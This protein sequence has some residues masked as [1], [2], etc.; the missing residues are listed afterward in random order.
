[1]TR[2]IAAWPQH[3]PYVLAFFGV[4]A[5]FLAW[6]LRRTTHVT[7]SVAW[8]PTRRSLTGREFVSARW[9]SWV[10]VGVALL[11]FGFAGYAY[12]L[13][14]DSGFEQLMDAIDRGDEGTVRSI[15]AAKNPAIVNYARG[16]G[17]GKRGKKSPPAP[18]TFPLLIAVQH[19]QLEIVRLLLERGADVK[20]LNE[21]RE[22]PLLFAVDRDTTLMKM[23]LEAGMPVGGRSRAG[24]TAMM[25]AVATGDIAPV[26]L[27]LE[28]GGTVKDAGDGNTS[29]LH[30]A[31]TPEVAALLCAHDAHPLWADTNGAMPA[32][33]AKARGD[34]VMEAFLSPEGGPCVWLHTRPGIASRTARATAV[35]EYACEQLRAQ[36]GDAEQRGRRA[37][38]CLALGRALEKGDA[39]LQADA[40][41]ART[42]YERAC[43]N[44]AADACPA[45]GRLARA[46]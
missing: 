9:Q 38:A 42:A 35:N 6:R 1:M 10:A 8:P 12:Y 45:A 5:L 14:Q 16:E 39:E 43:A 25:L 31:T 27:L 28:R 44:G 19:R 21:Y 36:P 20:R 41:R 34:T 40:G 37:A 2:A 24:K 4:M 17:G 11:I 46:L 32:A 15:L 13:H 18:V 29:P 33:R 30:E 23:L 7:S 22:S 3:F 26:E